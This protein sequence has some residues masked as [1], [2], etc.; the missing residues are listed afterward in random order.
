MLLFDSRCVVLDFRDRFLIVLGSVADSFERARDVAHTSKR[1][2]LTGARRV[3]CL[4]SDGEI[5]GLM[6]SI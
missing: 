2:S 5:K 4:A 1:E 3:K 6:V